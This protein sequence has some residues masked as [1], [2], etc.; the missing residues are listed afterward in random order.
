MDKEIKRIDVTEKP[1]KFTKAI[2]WCALLTK[3]DISDTSFV[4]R[5]YENVSYDMLYVTT[6]QGDNFKFSSRTASFNIHERL[7]ELV[8]TKCEELEKHLLYVIGE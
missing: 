4:E 3:Q 6:Y 1:S 5:K 2:I 7:K 8:K